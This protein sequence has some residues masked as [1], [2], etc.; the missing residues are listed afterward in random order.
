MNNGDTERKV[1]IVFFKNFIYSIYF[2]DIFKSIKKQRT[3]EQITIPIFSRKQL[4]D[5]TT[6]VRINKII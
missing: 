1:I 6:D 3:D 5:C 4:T 2:F